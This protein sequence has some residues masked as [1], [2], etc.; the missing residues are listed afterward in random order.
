MLG[1]AL[2]RGSADVA[3]DLGTSATRVAVRGRGVL[4]ELP[5]VVAVERGPGGQRVVA[6]GAD[7]RRMVGRTPEHITATSPLRDGVITDYR[8]ADTL[9]REALSLAGLTGSL[10]RRRVLVSVPRSTSESERRA[11]IEGLRAAGARTVQLVSRAVAAA[12]GAGLPVQEPGA[13]AIVEIGGGV[14]EVAVLS[15]GGVVE[16]EGVPI[17]GH[18]FDAAAAEWVRDRHRVLIGA[19]TAE[20]A[21]LAVGCA[22]VVDPNARVRVTGRDIQMSVPREIEWSGADAAAAFQEPLARLLEGMRLVF[23][24]LG[25]ELAADIVERGVVLSGGAAQLP[26]LTDWLGE[27]CGL[28]V[29][30]ADDPSRAGIR[31]S[32]LLLEDPH[33]LER[34]GL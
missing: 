10:G 34:L 31:G 8:L 17:G 23:S 3:V 1:A 25:P 30:L 13:S 16:S 5:S 20:E 24:R 4:V 33:A 2:G 32:L 12:V 27:R 6:V 29:V 21:K 26:G 18:T 7:A 11:I 15:L 22:R 9:L 28:P 14:T 19:R